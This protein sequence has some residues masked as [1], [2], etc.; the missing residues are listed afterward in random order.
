[1]TQSERMKIFKKAWK[2]SIRTSIY[3]KHASGDRVGTLAFLKSLSVQLF[4][5]NNLGNTINLDA[6][7]KY[8]G[9]FRSGK[10]DL[11][12]LLGLTVVN[13]SSAN[14]IKESESGASIY[15]VQGENSRLLKKT[16]ARLNT[17]LHLGNGYYMENSSGSS[18]TWDEYKHDNEFEPRLLF[19]GKMSYNPKIHVNNV[20]FRPNNLG[21]NNDE[22][23]W[24]D[25]WDDVCP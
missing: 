22:V 14:D 15:F 3:P 8:S 13:F 19:W 17:G 18:F 9:D 23:V 5:D 2:E 21:D 11:E 25:F 1:M 20:Y 10:H 16:G 4:P 6:S 7:E 12:M 24:Q